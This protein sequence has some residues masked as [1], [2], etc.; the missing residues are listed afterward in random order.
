MRIL[1][2]VI[3]LFSCATTDATIKDTNG[4][5]NQVD[6]E[7]VPYIIFDKEVN[8]HTVNGTIDFLRRSQD[9]EAIVIEF[10]TP[11]G[12]VFDGMALAKAMERHPAKIVCVVNGMAASM[13]AYLLQS[14]DERLMTKTSLI[15]FHEPSSVAYGKS[16]DMKELAETLD[17]LNEA[18]IAHCVARMNITEEEFAKRIDHKDW[19]LS[20][21]G[22][23]QFNVVDGV[24]SSPEEVVIAYRTGGT[25]PADTQWT[26][27][28]APSQQ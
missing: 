25:A 8:E 7:R 3:A 17:A 15:M 14:C 18:L 13:G 9:A 4:F 27:Q 2:L 28:P 20:Y 5:V 11:G 22:A 23:Q 1:T 16:K 12:S 24:V 6:Y 19:W 10:D 26:K 21:R